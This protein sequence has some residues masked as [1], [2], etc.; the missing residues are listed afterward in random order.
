MAEPSRKR[1]RCESTEDY[2][3][4]R[5]YQL[6]KQGESLDVVDATKVD[7][8]TFWKKYVQ[9]RR[10]CLLEMP[11][12]VSVER[13]GEVA[14]ECQVEVER[15]KSTD[16]PFGQGMSESMTIGQLLCQY[17][18]DQTGD[19]PRQHLYLSSQRYHVDED[20]E[21]DV[22]SAHWS[23]P[24]HELA[25]VGALPK[26]LP[27]A[28]NLRLE[29]CQLWMGCANESVTGLHHDYHDN[30]LC[31]CEGVKVVRL[32]D[33]SQWE[34]LSVVGRVQR[35]HPNGLISYERNPTRA[36]GVPIAVLKENGKGEDSS[37]SEK[38]VGNAGSNAVDNGE[39]EDDDN[40]PE[41]VLGKGFDY[42][43]DSESDRELDEDGKDDYDDL[44][45]E[46]EEDSLPGPQPKPDNFSRMDLTLPT[47]QLQTDF[48]PFKDST[49]TVV[50]VMAGQ[51]L[52]MPASW[53][54]CVTSHVSTPSKTQ[55]PMHLAIN[56]WYHPPD[57][58]ECF[59]SPYLDEQYWAAGRAKP[60]GLAPIE[61]T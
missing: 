54:H 55:P 49:D 40:E 61:L 37:V 18:Q 20:N 48:P 29:S 42:C 25:Q 12:E 44:V 4:Y 31:V 13:L 32:Y 43:S 30:F 11:L 21:D 22:S 60:N 57:R 39:S 16:E 10:P 1:A 52:Y 46:D 8:Q 28:G 2:S 51:C 59:E 26:A 41:V 53:F 5:G 24:C 6:A 33:P 7:A 9:R 15:R 27:L 19:G 35:V 38:E 23:P 17:K 36:D 34:L 50:E 3:S 58:S 45:G 56:Y 14:G 47:D